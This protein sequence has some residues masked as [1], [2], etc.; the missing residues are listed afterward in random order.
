MQ[1][2]EVQSYAAMTEDELFAQIA[3]V[4]SGA[5]LLPEDLR[6]RARLGKIRFLEIKD[7]VA[8]KICSPAVRAELSAQGDVTKLAIAVGDILSTLLT[9]QP[10][11]L[12]SVLIAKIGLDS[13]CPRDA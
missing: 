9:G 4:T 11:I 6:E 10:L 13:F 2:L 3:E 1:H 7:F 5:G 12:V 8:S